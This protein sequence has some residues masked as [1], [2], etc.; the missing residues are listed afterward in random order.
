MH[1]IPLMH[2]A[3][4]QPR[5]F[6][7]SPLFRIVH[8]HFNDFQ[9][10]YQR[11]YSEHY[12]YYRGIITHTIERF[13]ECGD[14]REGTARYE[15]GKCGHSIAVPF[16]RKT[17]LFCP[18]CHEKKT[19]LWIEEIRGNILLPVPHRFWTFSIPKRLRPFFMY[20]RKLLSL[21]VDAANFA[22]TAPLSGGRLVKNIRLGIVSLIQTH[23]DSLEFNPPTSICS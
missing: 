2:Q 22:L 7:W 10:D 21:M 3:G 16:S 12:G 6:D 17:R 18:S 15:C 23:S 20:N 1:R 5:R 19:L 14:P 8:S 4:Y 11:L 9:A 13:L